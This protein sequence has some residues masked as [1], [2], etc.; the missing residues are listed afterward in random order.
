ME[1]LSDAMDDIYAFKRS[2]TWKKMCQFSILTP[3]ASR[4]HESNVARVL[5]ADKN[6]LQ[7]EDHSW[8]EAPDEWYQSKQ[9]HETPENVS[10]SSER[11]SAKAA[12]NLWYI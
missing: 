7:S 12:L 6:P 8:R 10:L 11:V 2:F 1:R 3:R 4:T 9:E 5:C